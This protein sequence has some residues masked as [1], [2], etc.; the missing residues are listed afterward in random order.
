MRIGTYNVLGLRGYP[1]E[2]AEKE[3]GDRLGE[4]AAAHFA[5]VFDEL[6][7][8]V[9]AL[10]EGVP[11]PQIH[12]VADAMGVNLATFPSP[13][14]W[15]GHL[16][17]RYPILESRAFS[18]F[19]PDARDRPLSRVAGAA[20][21]EVGDG[22]RLW[23]VVIH[24]YPGRDAQERRAPEAAILDRRIGELAEVTPNV[25]V[26]GDYNCEVEE[27]IHHHLKAR[28]FVNT[29]ER[30]GGGVQKTCRSIGPGS[31]AIDHIYMSPSLSDR[32]T[33]AEVVRWP[34][35]YHAGPEA[36]GVWVHSDHL[37]VVAELDWP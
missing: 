29:M 26:L 37:P 27:E 8:D 22:Q 11:F 33:G 1:T 14:N 5:G 2:E 35:F 12:R 3:I 4:R 10:E 31:S 6:G 17:T 13:C 15:P 30:A 34:G 19:A 25:I 9:L 24:L 20:L 21:L 16:L 23:V 7:C 18:H 32:L 36:P 28:G